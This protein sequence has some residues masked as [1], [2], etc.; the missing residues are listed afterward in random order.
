M[1]GGSEWGAETDGGAGE[2][3][4]RLQAQ[5]T[6]AEAEVAAHQRQQ[7]ALRILNTLLRWVNGEDPRALLNARE[8]EALD[9][10]T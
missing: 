1:W 4:R 6:E 2:R 7:A 5:R 8:L 10:D 9:A 3:A